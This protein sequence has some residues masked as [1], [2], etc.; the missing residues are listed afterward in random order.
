MTDSGPHASGVRLYVCWGTFKHPL[1][2]A[3]PCQRAHAALLEAGYEPEV[4]KVYGLRHLPDVIFNR[5]DGRRMAK[6]LT[7][8]NMMPLLITDAG[9]MVN[10]SERIAEWAQSDSGVDA[11]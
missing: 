10:R 3:H 4:I 7:G 11:G 1:G 9:E 2:H 6:R 8:S 5:S